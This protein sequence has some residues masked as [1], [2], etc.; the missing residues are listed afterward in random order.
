[1]TWRLQDRVSFEPPPEWM[2]SAT[3]RFNPPPSP[4]GSPPVPSI[5]ISCQPLAPGQTLRVH[6]DRFIMALA[7]EA[8]DLVLLST[9]KTTLDERPAILLRFV[10]RPSADGAGRIEQTVALVGAGTDREPR[11]VMFSLACPPEVADQNQEVFA[12]VLRTVH[13]DE[14]DLAAPAAH[15][16]E[17]LPNPEADDIPAVPMPGARS[18]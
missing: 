8:Q 4:P 6:A 9:E 16:S 3:V 14:A 15:S 2:E 11:V 10:F 1:M 7:R 5:T 18:R 13:F 12:K 17:R